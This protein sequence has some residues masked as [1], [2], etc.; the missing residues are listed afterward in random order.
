MTYARLRPTHTAPALSAASIVDLGATVAEA[1]YEQQHIKDVLAVFPTMLMLSME[2][3]TMLQGVPPR[4]ASE[5]RAVS[6]Y[7]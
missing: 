6:S 4:T 1:G 5:R 7:V 2:S 3:Q